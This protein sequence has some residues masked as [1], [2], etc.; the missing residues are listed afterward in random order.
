MKASGV[1]NEEKEKVTL[2]N[3]HML[4]YSL[5]KASSARS[6]SFTKS[7]LHPQNQLYRRYVNLTYIPLDEKP[8]LHILKV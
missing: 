1:E 3:P 6:I 2:L 7:T 8:H 4:G 5:H